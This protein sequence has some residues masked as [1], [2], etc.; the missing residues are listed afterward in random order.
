MHSIIMESNIF[1]GI[2]FYIFHACKYCFYVYNLHYK[3]YSLKMIFVLIFLEFRIFT[4]FLCF[5][6]NRI[7]E[8][9]KDFSQKYFL[10]FT[11]KQKLW[12]FN[13]KIYFFLAKSARIFYILWD[14]KSQ[15]I[16]FFKI[17]ASPPLSQWDK[18]WAQSNYATNP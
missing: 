2:I 11:H 10:R 3:F 16:G 1:L 15:K 6:N 8:N 18:K 9:N 4:V 7:S 17:A 5:F 14:K 12:I 13:W